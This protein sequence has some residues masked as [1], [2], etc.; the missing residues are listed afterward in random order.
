[1]GPTEW[2]SLNSW[3]YWFLGFYRG[4]AAFLIFD[5]KPDPETS[6]VLPRRSLG[7]RSGCGGVVFATGSIRLSPA[8]RCG[9]ENGRE[10]GRQRC[11]QH[12]GPKAFGHQQEGVAEENAACGAGAR[13][14]VVGVKL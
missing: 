13:G 7:L 11:Q 10:D 14:G 4:K 5:P 2:Q 1:M 3:F 12:G 6:T 9:D 8:G